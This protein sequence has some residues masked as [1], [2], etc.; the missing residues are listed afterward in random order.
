MSNLAIP[1]LDNL[2]DLLRSPR[3]VGF[4]AALMSV[5]YLSQALTSFG[6]PRP[7]SIDPCIEELKPSPLVDQ[8]KE[9]YPKDTYS[10]GRE[11][12]TPW[13]KVQYW[14]MG[15]SGPKVVLVHGLSIPAL[16][17]SKVAPELVRRGY[18]VLVYDHF[19]RG[20]SAAPD[21]PYTAALYTT[22][23][24]LILQHA[25]W[26]KASIVGL[27]MGGA[28]ATAF[29]ANHAHLVD[30]HVALIAPA[31][32]V[33]PEELSKKML[34]MT[35]TSVMTLWSSPLIRR[36]Y[37]PSPPKPRNSGSM[38][39]IQALQ[40][41]ALPGYARALASSLRDG[42]LTGL[43]WAYTRL[44]SSQN[45][46][47]L[48]IH[49]DDDKTV[50]FENTSERIAAMVPQSKLVKMEGAG[51]DLCYDEKYAGRVSEALDVFLRG[52]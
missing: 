18:Q 3:V 20:Y 22:Q 8:L 1:S 28:I 31:G 24:A 47:V 34:V 36:F 33:Q 49:G 51:H 14:V 35:S 11:L 4:L 32:L 37:T 41:A 30:G 25:G 50:N 9:A 13:G 23:L 15:E 38:E 27:S 39:R 2:I 26:E 29:A 46:K 17:W 44:G 21:V 43:E 6:P 5:T 16:V 40:V 52:A 19:G 42:P 48:H 12:R 7:I 45:I 10:G